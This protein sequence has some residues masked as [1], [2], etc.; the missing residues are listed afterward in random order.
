M[1]DQLT[2]GVTYLIPKKEKRKKE[3]TNAKKY[4]SIT[5]LPTSY[6]MI[7]STLKVRIV[8]IHRI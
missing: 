5:C 7:T 4:R 3:T 2:R 8:K 6:E 1:P